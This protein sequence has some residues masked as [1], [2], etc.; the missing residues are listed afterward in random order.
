M[1]YEIVHF[2]DKTAHHSRCEILRRM[3]LKLCNF[4]K[5]VFCSD[6]SSNISLYFQSQWLTLRLV[7]TRIDRWLI[8]WRS[9]TASVVNEYVAD[10]CLKERATEVGFLQYFHTKQAD[11][12]NKFFSLRVM[13]HNKFCNDSI[14]DDNLYRLDLRFIVQCIPANTNKV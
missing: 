3:C 14:T 7:R 10:T 8:H 5:A 13:S 4:F 2:R 1:K 11:F 6:D 9:Y 12:R